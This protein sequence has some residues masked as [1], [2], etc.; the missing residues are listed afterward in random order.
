PYATWQ[1]YGGTPEMIR[2]SSLNEIDT[3]N[4][5]QLQI[6]WSYSSGDVDTAS[7][8]QIQ[9]N[10]IIIDSILYGVSPQMKL[11]AL[12]A[13][14]GKEIWRFDPLAS[15]P[16]DSTHSTY[17]VL[18][19]SR[20]VAYWSDGQQDQRLFFT[21]G[22]KT[23][24]INAHTGK[25][26]PTF[27]DSGSIDLHN[28]LDREVHDLFIVS[29]SPGIV[30]KD[31]LI[32]GSR[33]E[34][35][36]PAAPGHI[37]AYDVRTGKR[38]WIFHTIPFPGETGYDTWTNPNSYTFAGGANAW[39][40]FSLDTK[41]GILFVPTG[42]AAYDFYGG[43]RTG[44]NLFANSLIALDANTGTRKWHFQFIH[45]DLWDKDL[46]TPPALVTLT[47][48]NK[49]IEAAVQP[50]KNGQLFLFDRKTGTPL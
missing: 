19:N 13:R 12:H 1:N 41:K 15:R 27:A 44:Q 30:Y 42:S 34:E 22:Y 26:I 36:A 5:H 48:E 3:L 6:A 49:K 25:P 18:I 43:K 38:K 8:S 45:H 23:Y 31:L 24:A 32:M 50:T 47:I 14:T 10:P 2:Y 11:F 7:H 16:D 33:V 39:S 37:R 17:H 46:P 35:S 4:V 20:G 21:A 9:C 28:D 40:G 29:N